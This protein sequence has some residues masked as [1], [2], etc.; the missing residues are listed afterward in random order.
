MFSGGIQT[1]LSF[2]RKKF[3]KKVL[4][5]GGGEGQYSFPHIYRGGFLTVVAMYNLTPDMITLTIAMMTVLVP[6]I[7]IIKIHYDDLTITKMIID[8]AY[9]DNQDDHEAA[10]EGRRQTHLT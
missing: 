9:P 5:K 2:L 3:T 1:I 4:K 6:T 7:M 10:G 8:H